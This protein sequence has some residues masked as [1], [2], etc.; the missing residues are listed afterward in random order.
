MKSIKN[1]L[2]INCGLNLPRPHCTQCEDCCHLC[3]KC[4]T[5]P[6]KTS[7]GGYRTW[8]EKCNKEI[9]DKYRSNSDNKIKE[10]KT[11][12]KYHQ[13]NKDSRNKQ[14]LIWNK[15]NPEKHRINT[16]KYRNS[17]KGK[18]N[19]RSYIKKYR[20]ISK[21]YNSIN[22]RLARNLRGRLSK[23]IQFNYKTGS[24]VRDLGCTINEFKYYLELLWKEGMTWNNYGSGINKWSI[25]HIIPLDSFNLT[26]REE[27]L[28]AVNYMN[29]QPMW[30]SDNS[31]KSNHRSYS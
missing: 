16:E 29:L 23:A 3:T 25:D 4:N 13:N 9:K 7:K 10:A 28:K 6:R 18:I 15:N 11:R 2:C 8:C 22:N 26:I 12:R 17:E 14:S 1:K 31:R 24:A 21:T 30:N 5:N 20:K 19:R 27:M